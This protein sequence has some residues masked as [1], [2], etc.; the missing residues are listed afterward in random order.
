MLLSAEA[1]NQN[2]VFPNKQIVP[3]ER[4]HN[5]MFI[6]TDTYTG[7]NVQCLENGIFRQEFPIKFK[8]DND[9]LEEIYEDNFIKDCIAFCAEKEFNIDCSIIKP[10]SIEQVV[11]DIK[12]KLD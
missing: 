4:F 6:D 11:Y 5:N 2:I 10:E 1:F 9:Y 3:F 12:E 8:L 7:A